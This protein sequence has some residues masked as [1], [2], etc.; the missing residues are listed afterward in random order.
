MVSLLRS[1]LIKIWVAFLRTTHASYS[2]TAREDI[3][4]RVLETE[5]YTHYVIEVVQCYGRTFR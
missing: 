3:L 2:S 1:L 5:A 4:W